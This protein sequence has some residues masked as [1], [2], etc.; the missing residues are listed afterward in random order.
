M[1]VKLTKL[2]AKEEVFI[3]LGRAIGCVKMGKTEKALLLLNKLSNDISEMDILI[4][5]FKRGDFN[6]N[7]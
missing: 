5:K 6:N 4:M 1:K 2:E 7:E 3:T